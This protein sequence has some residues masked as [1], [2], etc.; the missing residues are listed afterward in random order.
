MAYFLNRDLDE[1]KEIGQILQRQVVGSPHHVH[2]LILRDGKVHRREENELIGAP[3]LPHA[4]RGQRIVG[5]VG[6]V[7]LQ[8]GGFKLLLAVL[9]LVVEAVQELDDVYLRPGSAGG[10][11]LSRASP[12][13]P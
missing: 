3:L 13:W 1:Y 2:E 11:G 6:T 7:V 12:P 10:D 9:V 4:D 5:H 8:D